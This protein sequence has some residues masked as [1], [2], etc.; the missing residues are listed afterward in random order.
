MARLLLKVFK[1]LKSF[2]RSEKVKVCLK[3][4]AQKTGSGTGRA[5]RV[6]V[7]ARMKDQDVKMRLVE[8]GA[9]KFVLVGR[10]VCYIFVL[11]SMLSFTRRWGAGG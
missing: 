11:Q 5:K 7:C 3:R 6:P 9:C 2:L 1:S 10:A 8:S 4:R